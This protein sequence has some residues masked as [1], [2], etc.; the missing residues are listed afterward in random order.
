MSA[1]SLMPRAVF[2][3]I[4]GVSVTAELGELHGQVATGSILGAV[5]DS[6]SASIPSAS[7]TI[8]NKAT[9]V[10]HSLTT[11]SQ[12]LYNAPALQAGD[13]EVRVEMQG[14]RTEVR[15]AQVLAGTLPSTSR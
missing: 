13:Y 12:G 14:F 10:P 5:T 3:L 9:G 15:S 8:T 6:S 1:Q 4:L 11:N 2:S 7:V